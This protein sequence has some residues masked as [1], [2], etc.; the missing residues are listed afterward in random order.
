MTVTQ[1]G[2]TGEASLE[3]TQ[4][5]EIILEIDGQLSYCPGTSTTLDA[6]NF[7]E[8]EWSTGAITSSIDVMEPGTYSVTVTDVNDCQESSSVE[9]TET[10]MLEVA[11]EGSLLICEGESTTLDAGTFDGYEWSTG[12]TGAT[13]TV[14]TAGDYSVTVSDEAGCTGEAM[15]SVGEIEAPNASIDAPAGG[16]CPG[17]S[18]E[19]LGEGNGDFMWIDP[20]N[21][22]LEV[23]NSEHSI[24]QPCRNDRIYPGGDQ[25]LCYGY[26]QYYASGI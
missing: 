24:R 12:A 13:L 1:A 26:D 21:G 7:A 4:S 6:G 18:I 3:V 20:T 23:L 9:V 2:C 8:Y 19:L 11:I 16:V 10:E 14:S 5:E 15:V 25:R 17:E 22:T